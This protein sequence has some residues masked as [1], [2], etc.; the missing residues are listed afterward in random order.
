MISIVTIAM[1]LAQQVSAPA[2][3]P[4][5]PVVPPRV[6]GS[7]VNALTGEPV[8]KATVILRAHD[9]EHALSYADE[10][11]S[12]GHFSISDV[13]PGEYAVIAEHSG[14]FVRAAG[15]TG[16]P[17]P[18]IKVEN[19]QPVPAVTI[20]LTPLAVITGRVLDS[21]GDPVR[22]ASVNAMRY[23]Y[24]NGRKRLADFD[25]VQ[26]NDNGDFRL[27]GLRAGTLYLKATHFRQKGAGQPETISSY[28]P[29]AADEAHAAPIVLRAG[30]QVRGI[31]IRL[32]SGGTY[33]IRTHFLEPNAPGTNTPVFLMGA[34]GFM[35]GQSVSFSSD[36]IV[37]TS[38]SPGSYEV[39]A[40]RQAEGEQPAYAR[41]PVDVVNADVDAGALSFQPAA[42][43]TGSIRVEGGAFNGLETLRVNLQ[44]THSGPMIGNFTSQVK[45]DGSFL[46]KN[47]PPAVYDVVINRRPGV[48]LKAIHMGDK[49][50][51]D[52]RI[53]LTSRHDPLTIILGADMGLV[54]GSVAN[55][56]GDPVV[57]SRVTVIPYGDHLGRIDLA[58]TG[59]SD[60]K[61]EFKI[62]D[63]APGDYKV[64]AWED[65]PVGA[66]QDPDYRKPF[67]KQG[68]AVRMQPNGHETISVTSIP[69]AA[70]K[71]EDQ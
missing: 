3:A 13:A 28:Y 60:E 61:G 27:F 10:T 35:P 4:A 71:S 37:F 57:R 39:V 52:R 33:T 66:P 65:V 24:S 2:S 46:L 55:A 30:A 21:D 18:N 47:A 64:F 31:D 26:T 11:D 67:E 54:E 15:A 56:K 14:Y 1:L 25:Q 36:G 20:Q 29:G 23:T 9:Q 40:I 5:A 41:L 38:V 63:V 7:V 58:R 48:Y 22:G 6:E 42:D 43:I 62:K 34:Q 68:V 32:Q 19:G 69:A 49:Q 53:D 17:P 8:R 12:N 44:P 70:T 45:P 59:F 16:A 51:A 50:L